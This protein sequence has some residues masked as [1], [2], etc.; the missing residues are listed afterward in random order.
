MKK[1]DSARKGDEMNEV[2]HIG[3]SLLGY[4]RNQVE[5]ILEKSETRVSELEQKL[6]AVTTELDKV[7]QELSK[8]TEMEQALKDG[9]VDARIAG[10]KIK[11]ESSEEARRLA[12]RTN[13]QVNQFKSDFS[14]YSF[15]L[16]ANGE[17]V[18]QQMQ[19][20]KEELLAMLERYQNIVTEMD[21]DAIYPEQETKL[22]SSRVDAFVSEND[23][24]VVQEERPYEPAMTDSEKETLQQLISDVIEAEH[25]GRVESEQKLVPFVPK[26]KQAKAQV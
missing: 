16:I 19:K 9:I 14:T 23:Q 22:F 12:E 13:E 24:I 25:S 8:Y 15:D 10:N 18:K 20:M 4:N 2:K 21:F 5:R 1:R 26:A 6:T 17:R 11:E 3:L 7:R